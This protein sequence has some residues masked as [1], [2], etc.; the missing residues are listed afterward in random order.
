MPRAAWEAFRRLACCW[1]VALGPQT[2]RSGKK[3]NAPRSLSAA[4][5]QRSLIDVSVIDFDVIGPSLKGFVENSANIGQTSGL[6]W[7]GFY[8]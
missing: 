7:L 5:Q 8:D 3:G 4:L 1:S 6:E 2:I